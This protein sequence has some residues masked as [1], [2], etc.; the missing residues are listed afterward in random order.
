MMFELPM[1]IYESAY[2]VKRTIFKDVNFIRASLLQNNPLR[3]K[4]HVAES[5][6]L[7]M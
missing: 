4:I 7:H 1:Y 3:N 2:T 6:G 5:T